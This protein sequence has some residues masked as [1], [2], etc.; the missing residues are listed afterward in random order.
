[1][2]SIHRRGWSRGGPTRQTIAPPNGFKNGRLIDFDRFDRAAI[3]T[4]ATIGADIF[5]NNGDFLVHRNGLDR[6]RVYA[7]FT[8]GAFLLVN[9]CWHPIT[10]KVGL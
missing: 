2:D 8:P 3:D 1:V 7:R 4:G 10:S 6:A 9:L 5:V